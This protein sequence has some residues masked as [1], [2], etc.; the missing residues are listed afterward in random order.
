[1]EPIKKTHIYIYIYI[2]E[3]WNQSVC[4]ARSRMAHDKSNKLEIIAILSA[5]EHDSVGTC[6][7]SKNLSEYLL[8]IWQ[9][10][11]C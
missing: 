10:Q 1:M 5:F 2:C 11:P 4:L 9:R 7:A 3:I 8:A 6:V